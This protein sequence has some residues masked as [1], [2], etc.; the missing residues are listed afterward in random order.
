MPITSNEGARC[1]FR[2]VSLPPAHLFGSLHLAVEEEGAK[3]AAVQ[4]VQD[5]D[6]EMLIEFKGVG[7][8]WRRKKRSYNIGANRKYIR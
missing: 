1:V 4:V 5:G 2:C 6:Q 3:Q 7:E 8:L